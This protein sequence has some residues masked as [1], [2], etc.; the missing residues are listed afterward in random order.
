MEQATTLTAGRFNKWGGYYAPPRVVVTAV[1]GT[2]IGGFKI[3]REC[4]QGA[5]LRTSEERRKVFVSKEKM[6]KGVER[7]GRMHHGEGRAPWW[8]VIPDGVV[9]A[10]GL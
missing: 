4:R 5:A 9:E 10:A 8:S 3:Q 7:F 1:D 6:K 2:Y